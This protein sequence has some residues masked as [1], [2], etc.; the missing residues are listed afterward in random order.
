MRDGRPARPARPADLARPAGTRGGTGAGGR[1]AAGSAGAA[2]RATG[3]LDPEELQAMLQLRALP[4]IG[5][6]AFAALI[7]RYG[8]ARAALDVRASELGERAAAARGTRRVL[9]RVARALETIE[10]EGL[11]VLRRGAAGYPSSLEQLHDPPAL[12]FARGRLEL[13]DRP[14]IAVVGARRPTSDGVAAAR[15]LAGGLSRA[16]LVVVS[17]MARGIDGAAH[18]AALAGGTVGV[19]GC[20]VDVVYPREQAALYAQVAAEGLLLSEFLP[21]EPPRPH[22][23]P[24]RN[25]IIAALALGVVVVE[26]SE[27]SGAMITVDHA[28]DLGREVFAVPG[29]I[30]R[31]SSAGTNRLIQEGA[32]I[33]LRAAD[34]V[35]ALAYAGKIDATVRVPAEDVDRHAA[36]GAARGAPEPADVSGAGLALWRALAAEPRHVDALAATCGLA[37]RDALAAL[38]DLEL[39]GY[40]RQW[41]GA[42]FARA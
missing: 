22:N 3:G 31:E 33:V 21:G 7:E 4:G 14:A 24:R 13:L 23:F 41:P 30:V 2:D 16:G 12:V 42:R 35:D 11:V 34:V 9:G 38:L 29:P 32:T 36:D 1:T 17:G 19:L 18:A 10:R 25:R 20:G 39:R 28:L 37:V 6:L 15:M 26:A 5:D 8:S 27:K 40:A